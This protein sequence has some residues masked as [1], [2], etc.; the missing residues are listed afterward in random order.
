MRQGR[1]RKEQAWGEDPD[2]ILVNPDFEVT[3][4]SVEMQDSIY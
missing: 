3:V 1:L 2:I 4:N